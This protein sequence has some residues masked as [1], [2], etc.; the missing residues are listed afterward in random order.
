MADK[1]DGAEALDE[2]ARERRNFV[3]SVMRCRAVVHCVMSRDGLEKLSDLAYLMEAGTSNLPQPSFHRRNLMKLSVTFPPV[4][5]FRIQS[6][7]L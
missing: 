6:Y 1:G 4:T 5:P 7:A 3:K 2:E